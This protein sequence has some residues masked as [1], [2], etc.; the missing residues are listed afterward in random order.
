[1]VY[2]SKMTVTCRYQYKLE[3]LMLFVEQSCGSKIKSI[4]SHMDSI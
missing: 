4:I 2:L 3:L 1:M